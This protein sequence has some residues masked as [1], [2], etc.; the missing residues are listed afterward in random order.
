MKIAISGSN[1]LVGSH[2]CKHLKNEF[3]ANIVN[4]PRKLLYEKAETL[5]N[6]LNGSDVIIHLSGASI[7][8]RWTKNRKQI[9]R[10]SRIETTRNLYKA[11]SLMDEKPKHFIC[12]SAVGIY[13]CIDK[14]SEESTAYSNDF[15]GQLCIDWEQAALKMKKLNVPTVIFRLGVVL[16]NKGGVIKKTKPIFNLGLGGKLGNGLQSFPF[17]HMDD[18][19]DAYSFVISKKSVGTYNLVASETANNKEF[20]SLLANNLNRPAIFHVPSFLL[21]ILLGEASNVL[22][23]GQVVFPNRLKREGFRHKYLT[24]K[25]AIDALT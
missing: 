24:L 16:S 7:L 15:L 21:K 4:I 18:L 3:N 17:I 23:R 5:A 9:L 11:V 12:T 6:L 2:L 8:S 10:N 22:L 13:N 25:E 14:H 19:L 1:G 20:T